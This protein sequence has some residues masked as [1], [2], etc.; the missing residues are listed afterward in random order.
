MHMHIAQTWH[1][2]TCV[3]WRVA[4]SSST[5]FGTTPMEICMINAISSNVISKWHCSMAVG[6]FFTTSYFP[7]LC[8]RDMFKQYLNTHITKFETHRCLKSVQVI[9]KQDPRRLLCY[10]IIIV[11]KHTLN[12]R[13]S[14]WKCLNTPLLSPLATL[15]S[16]WHVPC[17]NNI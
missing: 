13:M 17:L 1:A 11:F 4:L 3:E 14:T 9:F 2:R 8:D 6:Y 15:A 16:V 5:R 12:K 10:T 7:D